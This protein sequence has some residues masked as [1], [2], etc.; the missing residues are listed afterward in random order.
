MK[1]KISLFLALCMIIS[2]ISI[3]TA[4][5][6][7]GGPKIV[8]VNSTTYDDTEGFPKNAFDEVYNEDEQT[9][10]HS[11]WH[12]YGDGMGQPVN[13]GPQSLVVEFDNIYAIDCLGYMPRK[14]AF[15][16]TAYEY[17]IWVSTTGSIV[18]CGDDSTVIVPYSETGTNWV[19]VASGKW[20]EDD[21]WAPWRDAESDAGL[22]TFTNV[23]F[24]AVEAK[25]VK[26]TIL[27]GVGDWASAAEIEF[28]FLGVDYKPMVGFTPKSPVGTPSP[29]A[30]VAEAPAAVEVA[31]A[32]VVAA[33]AVIAPA[34][35]ATTA[36]QTGDIG[37]IIALAVCVATA[38][39]TIKLTRDK[40]RI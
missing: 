28:G 33:P 16:G 5:A 36:P 23:N 37:I 32:A 15:N 25:L 17:E 4:A 35:A 8:A 14:E 26:F 18:D 3:I 11:L 22:G 31:P 30:V 6:W 27:D 24:D 13:D 20:D 21:Y 38:F 29:F 10:W 12:D 40:N 7:T 1:K 9:M 19:K 34:P 39:V 2:L